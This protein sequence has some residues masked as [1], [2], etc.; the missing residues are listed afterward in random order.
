MTRL[1]VVRGARALA[2][3]AATA[4]I[5]AAPA[6]AQ[7]LQ[8]RVVDD[9]GG[10]G[11]S[12]AIVRLFDANGGPLALVLTDSLGAYR[13]ETPGPGEYRVEAERI[14][15]EATRSP[16]LAVRDPDGVY[17]VDIT[18][19]KAPLGLEG[20]TV[21]ADRTAQIERGVRHEI[22]MSTGSLRVEPILRP[23]IEEHLAKAH[24]VVDLV[25]WQNLP[26]IIVKETRDGPCFQYRNR[27]CVEVYVNGFR[28]DPALVPVVPLAT[29]EAIVVVLPNESIAYPAGAILLYT[30]GWLR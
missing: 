23:T 16:L 24:D 5:G 15:Y 21:T 8:G 29:V 30:P 1:V 6:E 19:R 4:W 10:R 7:T 20:I 26:S 12:V 18:M 22:G 14:G 11:V 9:T 2:V 13:V 28:I 3:A 25:R 27:G 17:A